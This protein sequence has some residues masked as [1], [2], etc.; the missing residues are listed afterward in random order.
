[1]S[2]FK[3]SLRDFKDEVREDYERA[4]KEDA[5]AET[6]EQ[7]GG[8]ERRNRRRRPE[9]PERTECLVS[10][11]ECSWAE[12]QKNR[13]LRWRSAAIKYNVDDM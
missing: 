9:S 12:E 11:T 5:A 1:M 4:A 2:W 3:V 7:N 13:Y 6:E 10:H 8:I